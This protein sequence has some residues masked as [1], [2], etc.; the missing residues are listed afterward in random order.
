MHSDPAY[1]DRSCVSF[2]VC[3]PSSGLDVPTQA[4]LLLWTDLPRHG[5]YE[6]FELFAGKGDA[7]REWSK[8]Q[9]SI[10]QVLLQN[11]EFLMVNS[12]V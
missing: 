2:R 7:T 6:F 1:I 3:Q 10:Y 8:P 5:P 12:Y 11:L 4:L 9:R